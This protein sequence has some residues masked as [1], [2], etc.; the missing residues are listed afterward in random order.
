[1]GFLG[2]VSDRCEGVILEV[3]GR[4]LGG[5]SEVSTV[6]PCPIDVF[7]IRTQTRGD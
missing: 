1:M 4:G 2:G 5:K 6:V 3:V 7:H